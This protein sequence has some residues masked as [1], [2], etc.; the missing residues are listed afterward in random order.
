MPLAEIERLT[1]SG[2]YAQLARRL[3]YDAREF[4]EFRWL[5]AVPDS[6]GMVHLVG[7]ARQ[8]RERGETRVPVLVSLVPWGKDWKAAVPLELQAQI[9]DLMRGRVNSAPV[10]EAAAAGSATPAAPVQPAAIL[11]LLDE[12]EA[13]LQ[14]KRC[15]TYYEDHM[16]PN[17]RR[18]ISTRALRALIAACEGRDEVRERLIA[19]LRAVR[20]SSPRYEYQGT[21]AVYD[22]Q[23]AGL[24]FQRFTLELVDRRWYV[25]E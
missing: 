7:R 14:A 8:R 1:S 18:T 16:S 13:A 3:R 17:F 21:R 11:K 4:E 25:A 20:G 9:E 12:A 2:F 19:A 22:L 23:G 6:G 10:G 24:P 5:E 15:E